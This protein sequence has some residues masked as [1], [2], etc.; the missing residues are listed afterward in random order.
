MGELYL[1]RHG[2]AN[3][4]A[5]S[6]AEYDRLSDLGHRQAGLLG[7]WLRAHEDGFDLTLT[8]AM[9]RH[10]ETAAGMGLL[11]DIEDA[12]LNEMDYFALARDIEITHGVAPPNSQDDFADHIPQTLAAWHA[13]TIN[14]TEPFALFESRIFD[15]LAAAA[16][17]GKRVICVTSGGVIAMVMRQALGLGP[18]QM[19]H[20]LLPI[21]NSSLHRFR[22]RE[23]GTYLVSFN[24]IPH[25]DA[26]EHAS[27]RSHI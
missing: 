27:A 2:Q 13:A 22:I 25:L 21:W 10:R 5:T 16:K 23:D 11:P 14:G 19:A 8:G 26:P 6:E 17:P 18:A 12:R 1:V 24:T 20:V 3:T 9:R 7:D 4:G 15:A